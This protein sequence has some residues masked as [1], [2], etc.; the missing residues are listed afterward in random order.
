MCQ[1]PCIKPLLCAREPDKLLVG[2]GLLFFTGT[3][4]LW[5]HCCLAAPIWHV[6][7]TRL[8]EVLHTPLPIGFAGSKWKGSA[9]VHLAPKAEF[10]ARLHAA[11][12]GLQGSSQDLA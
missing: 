11:S 2:T 7:N 4:G 1:L 9:H 6:L 3:H 10:F 12:L 8:R 5:Y